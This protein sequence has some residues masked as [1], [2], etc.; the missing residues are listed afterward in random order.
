[1]R[2]DV[3]GADL[4]QYLARG[5]L[6][7][8]RFACSTSDSGRDTQSAEMFLTVLAK[9]HKITLTFQPLTAEQCAE[10]YAIMEPTWKTVTFTSPYT[11]SEYSCQMYSGDEPAT[12]MMTR[13][14]VDYF[15]GIE[16][17]LIEQ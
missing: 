15:E 1:M 9:K 4:T 7:I 6:K 16:M 3:N 10:V 13:N 12:H 11:G 8:E 5:G 14:G 17:Q 2:F